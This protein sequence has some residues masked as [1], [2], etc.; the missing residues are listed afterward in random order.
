M[1]DVKMGHTLLCVLGL[2][3]LNTLLYGQH[4]GDNIILVS[5][6]HPVTEG[7]S[8]S[9]SCRLR[10]RES[11]STVFFYRNEE[12]VQNDTRRELNIPA[13][14][15]SD[16]GFYKC[17]HSGEESAQS[18][19]SVKEGS[20]PEGSKPPVLEGSKPP[21]L[22]ITG[23]VCGITLLVIFLLLLFCSR[24]TRDSSSTR[25]IQSEGTNQGSATSHMVDQNEAQ[26]SEYSSLLPHE[27]SVY[28]T[29]KVSEDYEN[30]TSHKVDQNEAQ[31]SEYSSLFHCDASVYETIKGSEDYVNDAGKS[32]HAT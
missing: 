8:V 13:V 5:P 7:D 21:V 18:W 27:A 31:R 16:E 10:R 29:I 11:V 22:L 28:E 2:F 3:L 32:E 30:A 12:V 20:S 23:L 14:S 17:G 26:C 15:K 24:R 6:V 4:G 19:M 9:L 25:P 1:L